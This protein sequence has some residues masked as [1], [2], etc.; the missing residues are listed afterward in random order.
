MNLIPQKTLRSAIISDDRIWQKGVV[1]LNTQ[2]RYPL[3]LQWNELGFFLQICSISS[4]DPS[5]EVTFNGLCLGLFPIQAWVF[6]ALQRYISWWSSLQSPFLCCA[7][8]ILT[9]M[10]GQWTVCE[11]ASYFYYN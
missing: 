1:K 5:H 4:I 3:G 10:S 11:N 6:Y 8:T 2:R 9:M 7:V